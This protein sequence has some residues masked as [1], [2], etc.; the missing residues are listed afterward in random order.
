MTKEQ[1]ESLISLVLLVIS[2]ALFCSV[3]LINNKGTVMQSA[4]LLPFMTTGLMILLSGAGLIRNLRR[5]GFPSFSVWTGAVKAWFQ[6]AKIRNELIGIVIV[7]IYIFLG[8]PFLGFY[9]SSAILIAFIALF[10]VRRIKPVF[11]ILI[12]LALTAVLYLVFSV[13]LGMSLK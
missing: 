5:G 7:A 9:I 13:G 1:K 4:R 12:A 6:D 8:I 3:F 11:S 10:Y 2:V